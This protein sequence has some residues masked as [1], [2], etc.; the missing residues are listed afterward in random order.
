ME[1]G[2]QIAHVLCVDP[3]LGRES[4]AQDIIVEY[5]APA[6]V[7]IARRAL[8]DWKEKRCFSEC[9]ILVFGIL[10]WDQS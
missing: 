8:S 7:Q 4:C 5:V 6:C 1:L 10:R 3:N 9:A 2:Q